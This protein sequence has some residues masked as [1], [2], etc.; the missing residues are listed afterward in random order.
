MSSPR[1]NTPS[2]GRRRGGLSLGGLLLAAASGWAVYSHYGI[3]H[4]MPVADAIPAERES[5]YH[6][7][8]GRL[9][10]YV[11]RTG[12]G[13]PLVLVHSVNAAASAYEMGPFFAQYRG[14]RPVYALDLP[15]FGFS[16]RSERIYTPELFTQAI[17]TLLETQVKEPA[18]VI[19]LSLGSEFAA[20]AALEHPEL[21]HSLT[22]ISPSGLSRRPTGASGGMGRAGLGNAAHLLLSFPLWSRP[23]FDLI[24]T[25]SS[26]EF[27]LSK[28]FVGPIPPGFIAYAY[29][30][31]HQPGAEHAPLYFLSG[32]L[33]TQQVRSVIYERVRTPT[34]VVYD[35]DAYTN[36]GALP[37]LLLKNPSWQAVRLVP[38][39]GLPHFERLADTVDVLDNFWKGLK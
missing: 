23:I 36:F 33:F 30:A 14:Q 9:N 37:D 18:D 8:T 28:S 5:L 7:T 26:I 35:R 24:A 3:N 17:V 31:A 15:G 16:E 11:D 19:A 1:T 20:R 13:R 39:L 2:D 12:S 34:L 38:S 4:N 21:I 32:K 29:A 25:R 10:Y 6:K 27:F 22:L